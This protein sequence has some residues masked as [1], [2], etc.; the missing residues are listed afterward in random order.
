METEIRRPRLVVGL[1]NPGEE[2]EATRHNVGFRVVERIAERFDLRVKTLEQRA[3]VARFRVGPA[4]L[5]LAKP[6]TFMNASGES[7]K[8]LA[9]RHDIPVSQVCVVFDDI[10]AELDAGV[11]GR[12]LARLAGVDQALVS[13]AHP[14]V[15]GPLLGSATVWHVAGGAVSAVPA[16]GVAS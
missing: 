15:V 4:T 13:S 6:Q 11:L 7:V 8:A 9:R 5:I 12:L 1:G 14:E 3:L 10:D 16:R 2:Y